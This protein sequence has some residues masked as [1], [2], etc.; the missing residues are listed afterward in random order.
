MKVQR[1]VNVIGI[2]YKPAALPELQII[3]SLPGRAN[4]SLRNWRAG[5]RK[6][7]F[8]QNWQTQYSREKRAGG[9]AFAAVILGWGWDGY[10]WQNGESKKTKKGHLFSF[11]FLRC[12]LIKRKRDRLYIRLSITT[13][14]SNFSLESNCKFLI[15]GINL[16]QNGVSCHFCKEK[17]LHRVNWSRFIL[18]IF[19]FHLRHVLKTWIK[20][21]R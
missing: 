21:I 14:G 19:L 12:G 20:T 6:K 15:K 4:R 11:S 8:Q 2:I 5:G 9:K 18:Q 13:P 10:W 1:V 17:K 3:P 16:Q 7:S